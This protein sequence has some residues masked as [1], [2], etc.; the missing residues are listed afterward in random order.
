MGRDTSSIMSDL[1]GV[2]RH[3]PEVEE[4]LHHIAILIDEE[5]LATARQAVDDLAKDLGDTDG[6][7]VRLRAMI[8][9][10]EQ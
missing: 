1:M 6:E 5:Q 2:S 3:P 8:D 9:F 10:L 7:I 4:R